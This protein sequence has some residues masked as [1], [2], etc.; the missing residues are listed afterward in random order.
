MAAGKVFP[1]LLA[2]IALLALLSIQIDGFRAVSK[3]SSSTYGVRKSSSLFPIMMANPQFGGSFNEP[4]LPQSLQAG[5]LIRLSDLQMTGILR[6]KTK[7]NTWIIELLSPTGQGR[8]VGFIERDAAELRPLQIDVNSDASVSALPVL[9]SDAERMDDLK[10]VLRWIKNNLGVRALSPVTTR[11]RPNPMG[12]HRY[13]L[14]PRGQPMTLNNPM[15]ELTG[16][17]RA[18]V[19]PDFLIKSLKANP[20]ATSSSNSKELAKASQSKPLTTSTTDT[21]TAVADPA[22]VRALATALL[23]RGR[24]DDARKLLDD[25]MA[26]QQQRQQEQQQ[27]QLQL[28]EAQTQRQKPSTEA[29]PSQSQSLSQMPRSQQSIQRRTAY[30]GKDQDRMIVKAAEAA[31]RGG[32]LST[33]LAGYNEALS[34]NNRNAEAYFM[35]GVALHDMGRIFEAVPFYQRAIEYNPKHANVSEREDFLTPIVFS[36]NFFVPFAPLHI[37]TLSFPVSHLH[38]YFSFYPFSLFLFP[39]LL[40][41]PVGLSQSR[42]CLQQ[43]GY[44]LCRYDLHASLSGS[45]YREGLFTSEH[46]SAAVAVREQRRQRCCYAIPGTI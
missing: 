32:D 24:V 10:E 2:V 37:F 35:R 4:S 17:S 41:L 16:N 22:L 14:S 13:G 33:A 30:D 8:S 9:A 43:P 25:H 23:R 44:A 31:H 42:H 38:H 34:L 46:G 21:T 26:A 27:L 12:L 45:R 18:S 36:C 20:R 11:P 1:K 40:V 39:H 6:Q 15:N 7:E 3:S 19:A 28:Q 5:Q 29:L